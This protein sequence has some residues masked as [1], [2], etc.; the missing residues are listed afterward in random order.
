MIAPNRLIDIVCS[1]I[2]DAKEIDPA[3]DLGI[4]RDTLERALGHAV[5]ANPQVRQA[6]RG[7]FGGELAL[8]ALSAGNRPVVLTHPEPKPPAPPKLAD[9]IL[10]IR[11]AISGHAKL[12]WGGYTIHVDGSVGPGNPG[13]SGCGIV[14]SYEGAGRFIEIS[15]RPVFS[16]PIGTSTNQRGEVLAAV[17]ALEMLPDDCT[18]KLVSDSQYLVKTMTGEFRR[19]SNL[20]VWAELDRALGRHKSVTASWVKGHNGD[21]LN[22]I[23]DKAAAKGSKISRERMVPAPAEGIAGSELERASVGACPVPAMNMV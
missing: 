20:D 7:A 23:A 13:P 4:V 19:K 2:S 17:Y 9:D 8:R 18:V 5:S 12:Q 16:V 10:A 14:F 21:P 22:E 3:S 1:R 15:E 11:D 6:F